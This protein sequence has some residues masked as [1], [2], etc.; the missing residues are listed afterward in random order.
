MSNIGSWKLQECFFLNWLIDSD[1]FLGR[2]RPRLLFEPPGPD[3]RLHLP[4]TMHGKQDSPSGREAMD[5]Q[6][7]KVDSQSM[8]RTLDVIYAT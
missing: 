3:E 4:P 5:T 6:K 1:Y 8:K 7:W 2:F